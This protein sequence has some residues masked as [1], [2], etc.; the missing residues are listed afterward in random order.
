M[1]A[2][3]DLMKAARLVSSQRVEV[4]CTPRPEVAAHDILVKV[5]ACGMCGS[6]LNAWRG[7]EGIEFPLPAGAPGHEVWGEVAEIGSPAE[8]PALAVGDRVTGLLQQGYAQ[9]AVGRAED[10]VA[11]PPGLG[12]TL[13]LGEPL[14]CAMN[15]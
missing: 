5:L 6:D 10:L 12:D 4:A 15:V 13:V 2:Y 11:L 14:A 3:G 7:V 9:Y 1:H 8:A